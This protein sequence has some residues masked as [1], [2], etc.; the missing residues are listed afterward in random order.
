VILYFRVV[1]IGDIS[2]LFDH[3]IGAVR[4]AGGMVRPSALAVLALTTMSLGKADQMIGALVIS[5]RK[6][7]TDGAPL[8]GSTTSALIATL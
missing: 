8:I 6:D 5:H 1:P 7:R 3:L 4:I 2:L